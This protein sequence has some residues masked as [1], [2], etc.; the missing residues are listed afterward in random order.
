MVILQLPFQVLLVSMVLSGT[1]ASFYRLISH[2]AAVLCSLSLPALCSLLGNCSFCELQDSCG[3]AHPALSIA[4][5]PVLC[6]ML[7]FKKK[8]GVYMCLNVC[9]SVETR[10][11]S[12]PLELV[13]QAD[14]SHLCG[15]WEP[16]YSARAEIVLAAEHLLR[17]LLQPLLPSFKAREA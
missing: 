17:S 12:D 11:T 2:G 5:H 6:F 3:L 10:G 9:M 16:M 4:T 14:L 1:V 8:K 13:L 15:R 7:S